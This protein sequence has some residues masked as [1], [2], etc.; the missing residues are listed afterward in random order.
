MAIREVS[1]GWDDA[2]DQAHHSRRPAIVAAATGLGFL[3]WFLATSVAPSIEHPAAI[4]GGLA[5]VLVAAGAGVLIDRA[6]LVEAEQ[7]GLDAP[8][9]VWRVHEWTRSGR[10]LREVVAAIGRGRLDVEP[11]GAVAENPR[12][13]LPRTTR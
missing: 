2:R 7:Q 8:R 12:S 4:L 1:R 5:A 10:A 3:G 6:W 11:A 9:R 13:P